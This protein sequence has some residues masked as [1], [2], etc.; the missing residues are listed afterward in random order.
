MREQCGY[1][2]EHGE[3]VIIQCNI[4]LQPKRLIVS[5]MY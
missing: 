2:S 5:I 3:Y 4:K 1:M